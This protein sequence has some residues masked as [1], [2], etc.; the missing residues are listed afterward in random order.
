M[1]SKEGAIAGYWGS[2]TE[3]ILLTIFGLPEYQKNGIGKMI[4]SSLEADEYFVRANRIEMEHLYLM[5]A[6]YRSLRL[7][8]YGSCRDFYFSRVFCTVIFFVVSLCRIL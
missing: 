6:R 4:I 2:T 3:S 8:Y 7:P 5:R 1:L